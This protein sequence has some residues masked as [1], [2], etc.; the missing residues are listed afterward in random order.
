MGHQR[1]GDIPT[2]KKFT[3]LVEDVVGVG[4]ADETGATVETESIVS[5]VALVASATLDAASK[6]I[7]SAT[8]DLGVQRAVYLLAKLVQASRDEENWQANFDRL[9]VTV[10]GSDSV[11]EFTAEVHDSL[12]DYCEERLHYSDASEMARQAAVESL[13]EL[14]K[15]NATTLFGDGADELREA[16]RKLSTKVGFERLGQAFFGRLLS[17]HLNFYL[18]RITQAAVREEHLSGLGGL[19]EFNEQLDRHC[20]ESAAIVRQYAGDWYSKST[21]ETGID[22]RSVETFVR[23]AMSKLRDELSRQ[24]GGQ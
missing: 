8:S 18:S 7:E 17:H 3:Q 9:G 2:S 16:V 12:T 4:P 14:T 5:D 10:G 20:Y 13:T 19:N 6:A 21:Y 1:L 23:T 15:D 24:G 11:F 22:D